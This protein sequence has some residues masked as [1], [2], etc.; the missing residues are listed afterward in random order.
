MGLWIAEN[1]HTR[2]T[3]VGGTALLDDLKA[4][5]E[6]DAIVKEGASH[7]KRDKNGLVL[8]PQPSDDPRDRESSPRLDKNPPSANRR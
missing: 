2:N 1:S 5:T 4:T 6:V 3:T 7:L 8:I